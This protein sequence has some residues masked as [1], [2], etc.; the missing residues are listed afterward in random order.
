MHGMRQLVLFSVLVGLSILGLL[1]VYDNF[2]TRITQ[3]NAGR[4]QNGMTLAEVE[5]WL[6]PNLAYDVG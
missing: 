3:E 1:V 5:R 2:P 6:A 4:I